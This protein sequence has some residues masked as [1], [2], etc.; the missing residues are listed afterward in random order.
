MKLPSIDYLYQNAKSS[1]IRFPLPLLSALVAVII[2]IY[3]AEYYK[4]IDNLFPYIN[5]MLTAALGIPLFFCVTIFNKKLG[6]SIVGQLLMQIAAFLMLVAIFFSLP[7]SELTNNSSLPYIRY[8]IFNLTFHLLVSYVP[9]LSNRNLNGF[10]NYNKT[11]FIRFWTSILYS[12]FLYAGIATALGSL[13]VLFDVELSSEIYFDLFIVVIGI[14]NTWFFVSGIPK[15]LDQLE[16]VRTYPKGLKIFSQYVLLPILIIYLLIL[17]S[18]TSKIVISWDWPRGI[19]SYLIACIST[20]GILTL[21]LIY[22]YSL[23][24]ENNWINRF[25]KAYY[26]LLMPLIAILF[27]AIGFRITDYGITINRYIIVLLGI[28]LTLVSLYFSLQKKNIKFIPISLSVILLLMSFGPWSMFS[29]SERSQSKR[30][31]SLLEEHQIVMDNK[32]QNEVIWDTSALPKFQSDQLHSN[33]GR[34]S[35]SL[36]NE[37][38][39][40]LDYLNYNHGFSSISHLFQQ[41]IDSLIKI[42]MDSDRYINDASVYMR[43][44]GLDYT[45]RYSVN[46]KPFEDSFYQIVTTNLKDVSQYDYYYPFTHSD[47]GMNSLNSM[48]PL[49][50]GNTLLQLE[51]DNDNRVIRIREDKDTTTFDMKPMIE[52]MQK[53]YG[54][55]EKE[56]IPSEEMVLF[57]KNERFD[58]KIQLN[59]FRL[60]SEED[61]TRLIYLNGELFL[62]VKE[63]QN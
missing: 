60:N 47:Y 63:N 46:S 28:W 24:K 10:W 23:Q 33:K 37:V 6:Y 25:S 26:F 20:L 39:S 14:F 41:N 43:S 19:V 45:Y 54:S 15:D 35:D 11:L 5:S 40:I 32:V 52:A 2:S 38:R 18:Y 55:V 1:L 3:M 57:H 21:L 17:Y 50:I 8:T 31:I 49:E 7:T 48:T 29:V 51:I 36:N 62:R 56:D 30:L 61:S 12:G 59:S 13:D 9:Y 4:E 34:L 58:F 44:L 16:E 53:K 42:S 27:L 22:P